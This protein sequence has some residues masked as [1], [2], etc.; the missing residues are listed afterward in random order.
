MA[1]RRNS[2]IFHYKN[3]HLRSILQPAMFVNWSGRIKIELKKWVTLKIR[4][5]LRVTL[6]GTNFESMIF[7]VPKVGYGIVSW[8]GIKLHLS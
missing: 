2:V 1:Q 8:E 6:Q 3:Q 7:H 5:G 4:I